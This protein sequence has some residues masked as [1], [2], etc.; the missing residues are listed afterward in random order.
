MRQWRGGQ[1]VDRAEFEG[2]LAA[3]GVRVVGGSV[4]VGIVLR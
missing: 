4:V 3:L 1:K 2:A